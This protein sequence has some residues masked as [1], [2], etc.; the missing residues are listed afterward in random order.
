MRF[1]FID[2]LNL[3]S[4]F[5]DEQSVATDY[6]GYELDYANEATPQPILAHSMKSDMPGKAKKAY[7]R[8]IADAKT[9]APQLSNTPRILYWTGYPFAV[10]IGVKNAAFELAKMPFSTI[11]GCCSAGT[12]PSTTPRKIFERRGMRLR[13][14]SG[15]S[16]LTIFCQGW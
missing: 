1:Y 11:A 5:K 2:T 14:R 12:T 13:W 15:I 16:L 3:E 6:L 7:E 9:A 8:D 4:S 10:A